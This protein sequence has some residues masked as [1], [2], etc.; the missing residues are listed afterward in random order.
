MSTIKLQVISPEK[1]IYNGECTMVEYNT[2]EG[3]VGVLPGHI[4][5]TQIIAPGRLTIYEEN[6]EKPITAALIS[7][8]VTIMPDTITILAEIINIKDEIDLDRAKQA[9]E[10]AQKRIEE[11]TEGTDIERAY[12]AL[13][14][15]ETR[16]SLVE[17]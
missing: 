16:I 1:V 11:K 7:G 3:Y 13:E 10:R 9:K 6:N 14:R 17:D 5:M 2:T 8:V 4:A 15:A 12:K